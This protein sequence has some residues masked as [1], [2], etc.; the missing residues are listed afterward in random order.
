LRDS[1]NLALDAAPARID[2]AKV[3][4]AL[5]AAPGVSEVHDL[6]VWAMSA[7]ETAMTAHLVRREGGDDDFLC[8]L[9]E[10]LGAE[11]GIG[12]VTL[13]VERARRDDCAAHD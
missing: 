1:M 9:T 13:Q 4:A 12:H 8:A 11:F 5:H 6:H 3:R 2:V 7:T 10:K